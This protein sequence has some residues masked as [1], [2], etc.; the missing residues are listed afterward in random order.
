MGISLGKKKL[1]LLG[2]IVMCESKGAVTCILI[3]IL[4]AFV[5]VRALTLTLTFAS[6]AF[7]GGPCL[8]K[9]ALFRHANLSTKICVTY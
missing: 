8:Q 3:L 5:T 2:V 4:I 6:P 7:S 9:T 1:L